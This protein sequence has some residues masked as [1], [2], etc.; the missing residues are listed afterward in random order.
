MKRELIEDKKIDE[1]FNEFKRFLKENNRYADMMHYMF[2]SVGRTKKEFYADIKRLY[3]E[4]C[5][6][7]YN[8]SFGD[9]LHM[10]YTL[11]GYTKYGHGHWE[12]YVEE[13]SNK[14][15]ASF[16]AKFPNG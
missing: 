9:I 2:F 4:N 14:W 3:K 10:T 8:Y 6:Y 11:G 1:Y 12:K 13:L 15:K 5:K 7:N 16:K